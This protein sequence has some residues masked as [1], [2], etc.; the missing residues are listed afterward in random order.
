MRIALPFITTIST[1]QHDAYMYISLKKLNKIII[2]QL[3]D[4]YIVSKDKIEQKH[5]LLNKQ[6]LQIDNMV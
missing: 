1:T 2:Y 4:T 3:I 5:Y 6:I